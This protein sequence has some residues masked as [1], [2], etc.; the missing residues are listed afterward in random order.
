MKKIVSPFVLISAFIFLLSACSSKTKNTAVSLS[1]SDPS[2]VSSSGTLEQQL[3]SVL[4]FNSAN[5]SSSILYFYSGDFENNGQTE[6]FAFV[7]DKNSDI[8]KLQTFSADIWYIDKNGTQ[9]ILAG[10][11][12]AL[13]PYVEVSGN[14]EIL[15]AEEFYN[16][17]GSVSHAFTVTDGNP[18][19]LKNAGE[20]LKK[21]NTANDSDFYITPSAF[22]NGTD[23]LAKSDG[24][25]GEESTG[26]TKKRYYLYFDGTS[27]KEYGGIKITQSQLE[28]AKGGKDAINSIKKAGYQIGDIFYRANGIININC[29]KTTGSGDD[30]EKTNENVTLQYA[31]GS[32]SYVYGPSNYIT[33]DYAQNSSYG[34]VYAAAAYPSAATYPSGFPQ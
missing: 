19:E 6:A 2:S 32:V 4:E 7:G 29:Y 8:N 11:S 20:D 3:K 30:A 24:T 14:K 5:S 1:A 16:G 21:A 31:N 18:A 10:K 23:S 12:Y 22:D 28:S 34:G 27:F 17:S 9:K 15:I 25:K 13:N 33:N 26:H